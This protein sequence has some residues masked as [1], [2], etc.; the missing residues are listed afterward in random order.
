MDKSKRQIFYCQ[1][2]VRT[3][4]GMFALY[5]MGWDPEKLAN[6]DGSW[7]QWSYFEKNPLVKD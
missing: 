3:T 4:T 1:S 2:G 7:I 6:Y 5:L